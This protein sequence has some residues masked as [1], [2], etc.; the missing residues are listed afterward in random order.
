M[1]FRGSGSVDRTEKEQR[2]RKERGEGKWWD[3]VRH[4]ITDALDASSTTDRL[5]GDAHCSVATC[6]V[7][8]C[9]IANEENLTRN[10]ATTDSKVIVCKD[11]V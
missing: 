4:A 6:P 9:E 1:R 8:T 3:D 5:N 7:M 11:T 10:R 2:E